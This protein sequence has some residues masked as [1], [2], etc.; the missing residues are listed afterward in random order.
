MMGLVTFELDVV[1]RMPYGISID[2]GWNVGLLSTR[3][4]FD[5]V[6][7]ERMTGD[8]SWLCLMIKYARISWSWCQAVQS[9][10]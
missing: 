7:K 9:I 2:I 1:L 4:L 10:P 6:S 5:A 8:V 3:I